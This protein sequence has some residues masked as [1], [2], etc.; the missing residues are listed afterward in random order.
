[1]S[2]RAI[3][4]TLKRRGGP[5]RAAKFLLVVLANFADAE[6]R[7]FPSAE[8][9][10]DI[11]GYS[12]RHVWRLLDQLIRAGDLRATRVGRGSGRSHGNQYQLTARNSDI[13]SLFPK[14]EIVTSCPKNSDMVSVGGGSYPLYDPSLNR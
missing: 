3:D 8:H 12:L 6:G 1:M 9:L 5:T 2:I 13:A 11:T 7:A 4:R 10:A 14:P